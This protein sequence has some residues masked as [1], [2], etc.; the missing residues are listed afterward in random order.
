MPCERK[1]IEAIADAI[2]SEARD[3]TEWTSGVRLALNSARAACDESQ[4]RGMDSAPTD[5]TTVLL[6]CVAY[7]EIGYYGRRG[8]RTDE[9]ISLFPSHWMPLPAAPEVKDGFR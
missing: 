2:Y 6:W 7:A 3:H 1:H 8:W 4:W 5:G 9:G